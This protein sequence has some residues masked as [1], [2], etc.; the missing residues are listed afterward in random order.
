M[1]MPP[2]ASPSETSC[3][4][5]EASDAKSETSNTRCRTLFET[6]KLHADLEQRVASLRE[7]ISKLFTGFLTALIA[8]SIWLHR[9]VEYQGGEMEWALPVLGIVVSVAWILS[10][11]SLTSR[12]TAKRVV[13]RKLEKELPFAFLRKEDKEFGRGGGLR[14]R[15]TISVV[16][17]SFMFLCVA[18]LLYVLVN[19]CC[20]S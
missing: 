8:A 10:A 2:K 4:C 11:S 9:S 3:D 7:D 20:G 19:R 6:Y 17:Y 1:K 16:P 12:L 15:W 14:R 5:P 13:L 18:W